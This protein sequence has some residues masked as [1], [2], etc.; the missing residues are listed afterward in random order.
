MGSL[1]KI[2]FEKRVIYECIV[3]TLCNN[4]ADA[5]P[6]G[7]E[8]YDLKQLV[9]RPYR[10]SKT[11]LNLAQTDHA[12]IN[13]TNNPWLFYKTALKNKTGEKT[14]PRSIFKKT[15]RGSVPKLKA[16]DAYLEV[17]K[18]KEEDEGPDRA[19]FTFKVDCVE[20][21]NPCFRPYC[22]GDYAIIEATIHATRAKYYLSKGMKDEADKLIKLIEHYRGIVEKTSHS[23]DYMKI[24]NAI[25][26][27]VKPVKDS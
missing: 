11:Y 19:N 5:A 27:D 15:A 26:S 7:V 10:S 21:V 1:A 13:L 8:T 9:V 23:M 16:A 4:E 3:T 18:I 25:I 12:V 24:I 22:R 14:L 20:A 2:G 6:M 17:S